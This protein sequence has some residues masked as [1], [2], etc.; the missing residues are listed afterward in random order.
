MSVSYLVATDTFFLLKRIHPSVYL[1]RRGGLAH[2]I[3]L[4]PYDGREWCRVPPYEIEHVKD[5]V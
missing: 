5:E 4:V 3:I 1:Q 2:L